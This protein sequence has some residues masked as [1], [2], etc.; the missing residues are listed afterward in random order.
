MIYNNPFQRMLL[1][2]LEKNKA[3]M[4]EEDILCLYFPVFERPNGFYEK[5][6]HFIAEGLCPTVSKEPWDEEACKIFCS[7]NMLHYRN[8]QGGEVL[9][10]KRKE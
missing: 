10:V 6:L 2:D 5:M 7:R 8:K 4:V 9:F 3:V 1:N